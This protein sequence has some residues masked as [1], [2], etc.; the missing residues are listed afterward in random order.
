MVLLALLNQLPVVKPLVLRVSIKAGLHFYKPIKVYG[1]NFA[2]HRQNMGIV[3]AGPA[4][5]S[6]INRAPVGTAPPHGTAQNSLLEVKLP[7][8]FEYST[9]IEP[10]SFATSA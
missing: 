6:Q 10:K 2:S 3:H 4:L 9:L 7:L 1:H 5:K 8:I